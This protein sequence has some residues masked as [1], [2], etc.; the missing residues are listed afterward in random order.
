VSLMTCAPLF[1]SANTA[2]V[3]AGLS[4]AALVP[5]IG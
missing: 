1:R 2:K 4:L 3:K 5:S